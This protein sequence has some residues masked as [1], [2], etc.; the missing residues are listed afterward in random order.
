MVANPGII[1]RTQSNST[2]PPLLKDGTV[3]DSDTEK[4]NILNDFFKD[5]TLLNENNAELP[6][7]IPYLV[8][9]HFSSLSLSSDKVVTTLKA[10]PIGKATGPDE[11]SN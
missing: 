1:Y 4:T 5:Q 10:V 2:V 7:T 6:D 9:E 3:F 11:I 8:Q